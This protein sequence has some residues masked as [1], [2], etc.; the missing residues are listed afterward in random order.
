MA[1]SSLLVFYRKNQYKLNLLGILLA[2]TLLFSILILLNQRIIGSDD[3]VFQTQI[4]PYHTV[5]DWANLFR[6][7][8][9][10]I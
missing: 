1:A 8:R 6:R 4:L 7:I 5:F 3:T 2:G 10:Y 9:V